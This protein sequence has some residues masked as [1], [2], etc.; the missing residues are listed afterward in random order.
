MPLPQAPAPSAQWSPPGLK[1]TV[2]I[3]IPETATTPAVIPGFNPTT[4]KLGT[5]ISLLVSSWAEG[6][7]L[8]RQLANTAAELAAQTGHPAVADA[9]RE[10]RS[11]TPREGPTT[12]SLLLIEAARVLT[13]PPPADLPQTDAQ[14]QAQ[15]SWLLKQIENW[16]S[17]DT[18]TSQDRWSINIRNTQQLLARGLVADAAQLL[19]AQPLS[20]DL[21]LTPLR[22][23]TA[24]YLSQRGRLINLVTTY[25]NTF[26]TTEP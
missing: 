5:T 12:Q 23:I 9:A 2:N 25:T 19:N 6:G 14:S 24:S 8:P 15:K 7:V 20:E 3:P 16:V 22:D 26:L 1:P 11:I 21:R 4:A 17:I 13:L 10:L 18:T